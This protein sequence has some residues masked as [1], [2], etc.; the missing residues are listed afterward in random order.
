MLVSCQHGF[1]FEEQICRRKKHESLQQGCFDQPVGCSNIAPDSGDKHRCIE[2]ISH[3]LELLQALYNH[4]ILGGKELPR[5]P[6]GLASLRPVSLEYEERV[7]I[8]VEFEGGHPWFWNRG[9]F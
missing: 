1:V 5:N 9:Q 7:C 8:C 2:H 3:R 4:Q 6:S